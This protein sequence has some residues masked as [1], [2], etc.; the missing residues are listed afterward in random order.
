MRNETSTARFIRHADRAGAIIEKWTGSVCALLLG[1]LIVCMFTG[2]FYRYVLTD[3]IQ[4]VEE[5]SRFLMLWA[6]FGAMNIAMRRNEHIAID[7]FCTKLPHLLSKILSYLVYLLIGFFL[8]VLLQK[9]YAM[10]LSTTMTGS[11]VPISM[12]W[13]YASVPVG[14][15]LTLIQLTINMMIKILSEFK[16]GKSVHSKTNR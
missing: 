1:L 13:I 3:P 4:W 14:A 12:K 11:L 8:I 2:V 10:V 16:A 6:G 5:L 7:L 9:G 15:L